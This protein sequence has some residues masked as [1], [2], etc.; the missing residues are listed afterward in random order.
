MFVFVCVLV[1]ACCC[2]WLGAF[3]F[4]VVVVCLVYCSLLVVLLFS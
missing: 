4:D 2:V 3:V 1:F